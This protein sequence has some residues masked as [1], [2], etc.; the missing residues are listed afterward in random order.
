IEILVSLKLTYKKA[1]SYS[2]ASIQPE[3]GSAS[4][5]T[6]H[7]LYNTKW[8]RRLPI[9]GWAT[10]WQSVLLFILSYTTT[11]KL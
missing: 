7:F 10:D 2:A 3:L 4:W 5:L 9:C 11:I 8:Y 1:F 6:L